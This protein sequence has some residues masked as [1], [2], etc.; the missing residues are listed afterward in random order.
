MINCVRGAVWSVCFSGPFFCAVAPIALSKWLPRDVTRLGQK[1]R[2]WWPPTSANKSSA[3]ESFRVTGWA[4]S[5]PRHRGT[6]C[7][8][9]YIHPRLE[10]NERFASEPAFKL[11]SPFSSKTLTA[12]NSKPCQQS[13]QSHLSPILEAFPPAFSNTMLNPIHDSTGSAYPRG[14]T[15]RRT[16]SCKGTKQCREATNQIPRRFPYLPIVQPLL[17][18]QETCRTLNFVSSCLKQTHKTIICMYCIYIYILH[19]I[20]YKWSWILN[21]IEWQMCHTLHRPPNMW[22]RFVWHDLHGPVSPGILDPTRPFI[23]LASAGDPNPSWWNIYE[24]GA[25][26]CQRLPK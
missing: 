6:C 4:G 18:G 22:S 3:D 20:W 15:A 14:Q 12:N 23:L 13:S 17:C 21:F 11:R 16:I 8:W 1:R 5:L 9:G 24:L 19:I 10:T 7:T 25:K 2:S 26:V